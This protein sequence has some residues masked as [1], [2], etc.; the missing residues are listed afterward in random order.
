MSK[1]VTV[2]TKSLSDHNLQFTYHHKTQ[3]KTVSVTARFN[4]LRLQGPKA[5]S[6]SDKEGQGGRERKN[7]LYPLNLTSYDQK[8]VQKKV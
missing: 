6:S 5:P 2:E 3:D 1:P 7:L 8:L 4:D